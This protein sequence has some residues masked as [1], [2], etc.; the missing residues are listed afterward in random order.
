MPGVIEILRHQVAYNTLISSCVS[1][2][3]I[4][5]GK[6]CGWEQW[7]STREKLASKLGVNRFTAHLPKL[8]LLVEY[9]K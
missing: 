3:H 5:E 4:N 8:S 7:Q 2:K 9:F 6:L 1:D